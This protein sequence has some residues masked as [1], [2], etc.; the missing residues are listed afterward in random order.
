M[1]ILADADKAFDKKQWPITLRTLSE[2]MIEGN[3]LNLTKI[4]YKNP[5]ANIIL[6]D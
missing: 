4:V 3:L 1:I 5:I 6:T 2:L